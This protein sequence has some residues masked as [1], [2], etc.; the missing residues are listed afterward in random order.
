[1]VL[2]WGMN[3]QLKTRSAM[4]A[5]AAAPGPKT[6]A[7]PAPIPTRVSNGLKEFLWL[8][9][10]AGKGKLLDLGQVSQNTLN[11]FI[12]KGFRVTTEDFL[13][14]W[15][16]FMNVEEDRRRKVLLSK[17]GEFPVARCSGGPISRGYSAISARDVP[18]RPGLGFVRLHGARAP[19][20]RSLAPARHSAP[21]RLGALAIPQPHAG[22]LLPLQNPRESN[23]RGAPDAPSS[24]ARPRLP[25]PRN[26]R[27]IRQVPLLKI[28]RRP[29]PDPRSPVPQVANHPRP[30][31]IQPNSPVAAPCCSW[32]KL[33]F[34]ARRKK[35]L[36]PSSRAKRGIPPGLNASK[37]A[38]RESHRRD[39]R[40]LATLAPSW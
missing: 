25:K 12:E 5:A 19:S 6:A 29:R 35:G 1:M 40:E 31:V 39:A 22:A 30:H 11:F 2:T 23:P 32:G 27:S 13:R 36:S 17:D 3:W 26:P 20:P 21:G 24:P 9:S 4:P 10:D 33:D 7:A 14:S 15:R 28:L 37:R 34:T 8:L 16:E 18:R 38:I